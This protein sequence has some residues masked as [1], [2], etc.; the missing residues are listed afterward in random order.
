MTIDILLATYNGGKYLGEQL[1]SLTRQTNRDWRLLV[2]DDGSTDDTMRIIE[3]YRAQ[4]GA[5]KVVVLP[6]SVQAPHDR[7]PKLCVVRNFS[8]LMEYSKAGG[9]AD[10]IMFCDQDDRWDPTKIDISLRAMHELEQAHGRDTPLLVHTNS[11]LIREDGTPMGTTN[12]QALKLKAK[13]TTFRSDIVQWTA[14]GCTILLNRG[15]L[16]LAAP[17]PDTVCLHDVWVGLIAS[18]VGHKAFIEEPTMDYRQHDKNVV[19]ALQPITPGK[20]IERFPR[21]LSELYIQ[22]AAL[23]ARIAPHVTPE[24]KN[25][26]ER[27]LSLGRLPQ[28]LR[29]V[30]LVAQ[31]YRRTP[32]IYNIVMFG[33]RLI[34]QS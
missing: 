27:F 32:V 22:A 5:E 28:P 29:G 21:I 18:G 11:R 25:D 7:N 13:N 16:A 15:L 33:G 19:G 30:L 34:R 31:G 24:K 8:A 20:V 6:P 1:D 4:H 26:L 3:H 9:K 17:V 12:H 14:Q 2:R 23:H 10:Y